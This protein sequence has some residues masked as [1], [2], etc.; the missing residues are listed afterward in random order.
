[1]NACARSAKS[2][3]RSLNAFRIYTEH[4]YFLEKKILLVFLNKRKMHLFAIVYHL[5]DSVVMFKS[6]EK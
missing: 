4:E 2:A 3:H 6:F 5:W 1:M